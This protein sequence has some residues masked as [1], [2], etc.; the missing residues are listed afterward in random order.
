M[1]NIKKPVKIECESYDGCEYCHLA[2]VEVD[3][4]E[5]CDDILYNYAIDQ[6]DKYIDKLA[7][8]EKIASIIRSIQNGN[9]I[10]TTEDVAKAICKHIKGIK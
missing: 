7:D 8:E 6:Y 9:W 2:D 4:N 10:K 1:N 5:S 3:R